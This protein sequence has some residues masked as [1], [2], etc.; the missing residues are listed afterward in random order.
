MYPWVVPFVIWSDC[1]FEVLLIFNFLISCWSDDLQPDL[2]RKDSHHFECHLV[3]RLPQVLLLHCIP[4]PPRRLHQCH[5]TWRQCHLPHSDLPPTRHYL[6]DWG[7]GCEERRWSRW[8]GGKG[9][10]TL[11]YSWCTWGELYI[12]CIHACNC[13]PLTLMARHDKRILYI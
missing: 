4:L 3:S 9:H 1:S 13:H 12:M 8:T 2:G 7:G 5:K 6:H 11:R 10:G